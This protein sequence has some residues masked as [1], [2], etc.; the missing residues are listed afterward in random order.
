M[1]ERKLLLVSFAS[2]VVHNLIYGFARQKGMLYAGI[3][4]SSLTNTN[5]SLMSS[6]ASRMVTSTEQGQIQGALFGLAAL[7]E[8]IGPV[9]FNAIYRHWHTFGPG[10]MFVVGAALY[11]CGMIAVSLVPPKPP[12][13]SEDDVSDDTLDG[14]EEEQQV[15]MP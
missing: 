15:L 12:T 2:G 9:F 14:S 7:A 13:S 1:G 11:A 8:A 6:L 10:T 3:G 4:L 5:N